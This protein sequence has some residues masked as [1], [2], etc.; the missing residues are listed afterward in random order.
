M[1]I[2]KISE[3]LPNAFHN[4]WRAALNSDILNIVEKGG[5]GSGKSSDVAHIITQLLMRFPVNAIGIR[6]IDNT[7]E[8]SIF[9]QMKWAISEQ[10][11]SHLFKVNKSPM[12]ITYIPRGNYMA[13]SGAQNPERLKSLK[14]AKF[15]FAI[16]WI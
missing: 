16:C 5:R 4:T 6:H 10:G 13:F 11:V 1:A 2:K 8:L 15:P 3:C 9:E 7:L 12:K 14:D